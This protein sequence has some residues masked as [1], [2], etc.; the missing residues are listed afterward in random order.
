MRG[1]G[2]GDG[3]RGSAAGE[4][5]LI[6]TMMLAAHPV[7]VV[8]VVLAM[9]GFVGLV[10]L[11]GPTWLVASPV[12]IL[13][14][15]LFDRV[16]RRA[17]L[18]GRAVH[19][20]AEPAL[21]ALVRSAAARL[22]VEAPILVRVVP[23]PDA[24]MITTT[25]A[26]ARTLVLILGRPFLRVLTEGQ[27][28]A[29]VAHEL[30]HGRHADDRRSSWLVAARDD[31][32][33]AAGHRVR[34]PA[35]LADRLL[36][37]SQARCWGLELAA[38]A[39][40]A[41]VAG[42]GPARGALERSGPIEVVFDALVERWIT[43][44]LRDGAYPADLYDALAAALDDP[45][46]AR[47]AAA[48]TAADERLDALAS[49][50]PLTRRLAALPVHGGPAT[51]GLHPIPLRDRGA[52]DRWCALDLAGPVAERL[53]PARILDLPPER[54]DLPVAEARE[55]LM[56]ATGTASAA[57]AVAAAADAVAA[58]RWPELAVSI[59]PGVGEVPASYRPLA[60][61]DLLIGVVGR[62]LAALLLDAG[63]PRA[64]RWVASAVVL[65]DGSV[66]DVSQTLEDA[67]ST[68]D[69]APVR[70]LLDAAVARTA[71]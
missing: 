9:A 15:G 16:M 25:V 1:A 53:R 31:L 8:A 26:G 39:D 55:A 43:V 37:A 66:A 40:A 44:L 49:H 61:R 68:H 58:G 60:E 65:S 23:T 34:V 10:V 18:P 4:V 35:A 2:A 7:A 52:I 20:E 41:R 13:A 70:A 17:E 5:A 28:A 71:R 48:V 42:S 3:G 56:D 32:A 36:R 21:T 67:L 45:V 33:D 19:P 46:I 6:V 12:V 29:V 24:A 47:R 22:G 69:A 64:S 14:L 57:A 50:P 38:D 51:G 59:D 30:A 54:F 62:P 63:L 11:T 27:L